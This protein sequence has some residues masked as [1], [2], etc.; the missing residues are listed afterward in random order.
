[1]YRSA[2]ALGTFDARK[3][4]EAKAEQAR[5][6]HHRV[7]WVKDDDGLRAVPVTLGLIENQF[8]EVLDGLT[9]NQ[10]VVTGTDSGAAPR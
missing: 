4:A 5:K 2:D 3:A 7:V 1:M 9:Q 10:E 8:A 6:R